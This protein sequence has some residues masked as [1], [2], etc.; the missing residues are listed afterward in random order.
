MYSAAFEDTFEVVDPITAGR[1]GP[2]TSLTPSVARIGASVT[3]LDLDRA[4]VL[5]GN[6]SSPAMSE[7]TQVGHL[8]TGVSSGIPGVTEL[9]IDA[10]APPPPRAF[11]TAVAVGPSRVLV[12]G[13]FVVASGTAIDPALPFSYLVEVDPMS[14]QAVVTDLPFDADPAG[15]ADAIPILGGD[16]LITGGSPATSFSCPGEPMA[17]YLCALEDAHRFVRASETLIPLDPMIV[18]RW[19]HRMALLA[20]ATVLVTGGLRYDGGLFVVPDAELWNPRTEAFDPAAD[21]PA[22]LGGT[23]MRA[24]GDIARNLDGT[25]ARECFVP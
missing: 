1:L 6:V 9:T 4:L 14:T 22:I 21:D 25:P 10:M 17:S 18:P 19:G 24:P 8:L 11:H 13:G 16:V 23:M 12:T 5:G 15:Y 3:H 20:D 7:A 2:I